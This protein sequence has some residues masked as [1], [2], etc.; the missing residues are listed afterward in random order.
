[1]LVLSVLIGIWFWNNYFRIG[2]EWIEP[3]V[4]LIGW[5]AIFILATKG[6]LAL[7]KGVKRI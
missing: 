1:M 5:A 7:V 3:L 2:P 4:F 6:F